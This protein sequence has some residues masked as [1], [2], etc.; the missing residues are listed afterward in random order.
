MVLNMFKV[1]EEE[2][3]ELESRRNG[4]E[5]LQESGR[6]ELD[7][8]REELR[9]AAEGLEGEKADLKEARKVQGHFSPSFGLLSCSHACR[10]WLKLRSPRDS[11]Y[12]KYLLLSIV[13]VCSTLLF[14]AILK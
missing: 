14:E 12:G 6:R 11:I 10:R 7:A 9:L 2:S 13:V 1:L 4:L 5:E 8:G 3:R